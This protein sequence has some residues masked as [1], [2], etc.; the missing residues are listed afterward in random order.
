[1]SKIVDITD[2]LSFDENPKLTIKGKELEVNAD[3]TTVL[4][5]MGIVGDGEGVSVKDIFDVYEIL[6]SEKARKVIDGF[7][8]SID[9][10]KVLVSE[11]VNLV[12]GEDDQGEQ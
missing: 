8:L 11:A 3:A 9:D 4:K 12:T 10:F 5:I 1:M 6:F 2:K 7:K